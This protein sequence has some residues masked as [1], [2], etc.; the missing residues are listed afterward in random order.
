MTEPRP[1]PPSDLEEQAS[2]V[3]NAAEAAALVLFLSAAADSEP[4][5]ADTEALRRIIATLAEGIV[6]VTLGAVPIPSGRA[7]DWPVVEIADR[8]VEAVRGDRLL[9]DDM[10]AEVRAIRQSI[11]AAAPRD[12]GE[13]SLEREA[14]RRFVTVLY[15]RMVDTLAPLLTEAR[16]PWFPASL[17]LRKTWI[18]RMDSRVR[19]LHRRLHGR[20]K[21]VGEDFWRWPVSGSRLRWPGDPEAPLDATVNCRCILWLSWSTPQLISQAVRPLPDA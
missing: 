2:Q 4:S 7:R 18:T 13:L 5:P 17:K 1:A 9:V 8:I 14:A 19:P 11:A 10:R 15:A 20:T 21:I 16:P 12:P 6:K 3:R